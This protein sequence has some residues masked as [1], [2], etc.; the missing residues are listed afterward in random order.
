[1]KKNISENRVV[2]TGVGLISSLGM[3]R[4]ANWSNLLAGKEGIVVRSEWEVGAQQP[5]LFGLMEPFEFLEHF[6]QLK[7]PYPLKYSQLAMMG[8]KLAIA[9]AGLETC[10]EMTGLIVN[11]DLG[12]TAAA[13]SYVLKLYTKGPERV[14]PFEFTKSV[15][16]CAIGDV[17]RIFG[18]KGP[19]SFIIGENP[20]AYAYDLLQHGKANM[21]I[22]GGFDEIRDRM[23]DGYARRNWLL[24]PSGKDEGHLLN[25]ALQSGDGKS[26]IVLGEGSCFLVLETYESA[27]ARKARIYAELSD[28]HTSC[29]SEC[30]EVIYKRNYHDLEENMTTLLERNSITT[31][32]VGMISGASCL[33]WQVNQLELELG[34]N[35]WGDNDLTIFNFKSRTGE[36]FSTGTTAATAL[37]ALSLYHGIVPG[38]DLDGSLFDHR[39]P[40]VKI[41]ETHTPLTNVD[42]AIAMSTQLGGNITSTLIKRIAE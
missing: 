40:V 42:Y 36:S 21:M 2:I 31:S 1:M 37:A 9:D 20:V 17:A 16:N 34:N 41:P 11:S 7:P 12:A 32:E 23:V 27:V 18:L 30:N 6:P 8:V 22:C 5:Q 14:S 4:E 3:G 38:N 39:N 26:T 29:D 13:E 24:S 33:P 28:Y 35:L 10:N 25:S 15:S 19:S